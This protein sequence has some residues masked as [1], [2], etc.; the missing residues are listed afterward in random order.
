MNGRIETAEP[1][2][3]MV[4]GDAHVGAGESALARSRWVAAARFACRQRPDV[5][6]WIGDH[7]DLDCLD[8]NSKSRGGTG[9]SARAPKHTFLQEI[10]AG[11]EAIEAFLGEIKRYNTRASRSGHSER[12]YKPR[13][14]FC[15]GNHEMRIDKAGGQLEEFVDLLDTD[16]WITRWLQG[17]GFEVVPFLDRI[18]IGGVDFTHYVEAGSKR[19]AVPIVHAARLIG[20]STVWGHT[21]IFGYAEREIRRNGRPSEWDKWMCLPTFKNPSRLEVGQQSAIVLLDDVRG[22]DFTHSL[23]ST[24][25]LLRDYGPLYRAAA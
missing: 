11:R 17:R 10:E 24:D 16:T 6:V 22:G 25:R 7:W 19:H 15:L 20:R 12:V 21:H 3:V 4:I 2:R 14:V 18:S 8:R 5:I 9:R 1:L 23:V 13:L